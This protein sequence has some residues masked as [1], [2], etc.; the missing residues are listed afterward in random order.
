MS[1]A[2]MKTPEN[3]DS[4]PQG[5][6]KAPKRNVSKIVKNVVLSTIGVLLVADATV[7]QLSTPSKRLSIN[8]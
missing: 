7:L 1:E 2:N 5:A 4:N 3:P 6:E 8:R